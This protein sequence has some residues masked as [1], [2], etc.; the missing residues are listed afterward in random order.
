MDEII[1]AEVNRVSGEVRNYVR[2]RFTGTIEGLDQLADFVKQ[3]VQAAIVLTHG[4]FF[5]FEC[6]QALIVGKVRC[7][8]CSDK[9]E[10]LT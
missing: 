10:S 8:S 4:K 5:C 9:K 6:S 7:P 2:D 1:T 3:Q